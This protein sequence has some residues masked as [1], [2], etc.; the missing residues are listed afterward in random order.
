MK[1]VVKK[2]ELI[3]AEVLTNNNKF[4]RGIC[5]SDGTG[6]SEFGR[7][8]YNAQTC[9]YPSH[10]VIESKMR[11]KLKKGYTPLKTVENTAMTNPIASRD[12]GNH[13]LRQIA[14]SQLIKSSNP[15]LDRLIDRLVQANVH[16]ITSSTQ[17]TFNSSTGLFSTP[18]GIVT[19]E[20]I[21]EAR[22]LL[23]R[24]NQRIAMQDWSSPDISRLVSTYLRIVPQAVGM[25]LNIQNLFPD[26]QA[27]QKQSDLLDS[28]ESSYQAMQSQPAPATN[29]KPVEKVFAVDMDVL[30]DTRE[31]DRINRWYESSKKDMHNYG[32]IK[33]REI[34][35]VNLHEMTNGY[36][37]RTSPHEEVWH[38]TSQANC[39]SILKSGLKCSPPSTAAIAGKMFGNGVYGAKNSSKSLGYTLGRWGQS[40]GDS[41]WLFVCDFAMGKTHTAHGSCNPP[42]GYDSIWARAG[43]GLYNDELIVY[44]NSQVKIKYL[45]ECK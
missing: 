14:R 12:V 5:Y 39:L 7:V 42:H 45:L 34:Y 28:L 25:K 11:Q 31:R 30:N 2:Y 33:I 23:P 18:L 41:G 13:E 1:T 38:G 16:K 35:S 19:P 17:I 27:I 4:W 26:L 36:E 29:G 8:G 15:T 10:A 32:G 44:R 6:A 37:N 9:D 22:N 24:I 21:T 40:T 43:R 20:G 3:L